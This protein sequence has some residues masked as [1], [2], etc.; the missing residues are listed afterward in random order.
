MKVVTTALISFAASASIF[1][2]GLVNFANTP[3]TLVSVQVSPLGPFSVM[4]APQGT[5][6]FGLFLGQPDTTWFFTGLFATNT[7]TDG[8]FTGGVVAVPGWPVGVSTNYFIAGW[9]GGPGF[10]P[11]WLAFQGLPGFFGVSGAIATGAAGDGG[12]APTL[13]LFDGGV[14]TLQ[15]GFYLY[16]FLV[17]EPSTAAIATIGTGLL[18][19]RCLRRNLRNHKPIRNENQ[20]CT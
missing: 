16:N 18:F 4:S 6:S 17:P 1:A 15:S 9:S 20:L 11:A 14:G 13:N 5:Y 12:A 7:G 2:Q 3:N 8:L 10:A 19:F